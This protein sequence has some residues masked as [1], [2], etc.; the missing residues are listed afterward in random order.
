MRVSTRCL[1]IVFAALTSLV[2]ATR[3]SNAGLW[4]GVLDGS[5]SLLVDLAVTRIFRVGCT[6]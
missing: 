6:Q 5:L 1:Q 3:I 4:F 2:V